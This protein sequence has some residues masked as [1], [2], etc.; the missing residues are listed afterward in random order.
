[1]R[2]QGYSYGEDPSQFVE[3]HGDGDDVAVVLH[4]GFWKAEYDRTLMDAL[5]EDLAQRGW[6]AWNVEFR[7]LGNGGG[8][9]ETLD[10]VSAAIDMLEPRGR[11]VAI[12]HS[13]GGQLAA[14]AATRQNPRVPVTGVV[15]QAGVLDLRRASE[16]NLSDGVV[17]RFLKGAPTALAS[18][19]ERLP[20]GVPALLTHAD[21][22]TRSRPRSARPS[23]PPQARTRRPSR[24]GPLRP[25]RPRQ[26]PVEGGA[27][28]AVTR[29]EA[30]ELDARD[31]LASF[32]ERFVIADEHSSTSAACSVACRR[33]RAA[34]RSG[35]S[36]VWGQ[37]LVAGKLVRSGSRRRR[38][39]RRARRGPRRAAGEVL[40]ADSTTVNLYKLV[41][42]V[43][44]A[45]RR[46]ARSSPTA[47]SSPRP[48]RTRGDR[49][50]ARPRCDSSTPPDP[51]PRP[52]PS[53]LDGSGLAV[54]L[55]R[56]LPLGRSRS[57]RRRPEDR[58]GSL[59]STAGAVPVGAER[60]RHGARR[61]LRLRVPQR[62]RPAPPAYLHVAE[63]LQ[64]ELR[65]PIQ[66]GS[67]RP[68]SSRWSTPTTAPGIA[69]FLPA[70]RRS[71]PLAAVEAGARLTAERGSSR[72]AR[73]RSRATELMIALR[74]RV[75]GAARFEL[76][77][78]RDP[79]RRG[80]HLGLRH[81]EA[82]PIC[83]R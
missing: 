54:Y 74:R 79:E 77:S 48:L 40:V 16:L 3:R 28:V 63:H 61:R 58:L 38:G 78:P 15:S 55:A 83:A 75:A 47:T 17:E 60:G 26:P 41:C 57:R 24:R 66:A 31:P 11:V 68:T 21:S 43:L 25:P 33:H 80:S 46:C 19:I 67:G 6:T 10:D 32:R 18:P 30:L 37:A 72:C 71:S 51:L 9:P 1:M 44:D 36:T 73:S 82:W 2:Q 49:G 81:P 65:S 14:W 70:P 35:S 62:R 59:A 7:R 22:T 50:V 56:R 4:G 29:N 13:A 42:A 8:V 64:D 45:D 5:C 39:R 53:D 12:G 52:Q 69:R 20:L 34:D 23:R 27:R 76:G